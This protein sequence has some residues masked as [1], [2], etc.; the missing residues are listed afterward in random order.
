MA[1]QPAVNRRVVGSSP[2][3]G[4]FV[5]VFEKLNTRT[6]TELMHFPR[7]PG[8]RVFLKGAGRDQDLLFPT[9]RAISATNSSAAPIASPASLREMVPTLS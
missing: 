6:P 3:S 4:V 9:R 1:E 5:T 7:Q 8:D 2:T